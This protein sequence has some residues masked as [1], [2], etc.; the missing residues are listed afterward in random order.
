MSY[1][2]LTGPGVAE[3]L[4]PFVIEPAMPVAQ[5]FARAVERGPEALTDTELLAVLL[6]GA[7]APR[8]AQLAHELIDYFGDLGRLLND[9]P[10]H[11]AGVVDHRT[12]TYIG[13]LRQLVQR[14]TQGRATQRRSLTTWYELHGYLMATMNGRS[15]E[16]L[17]V[18]YLDN[19]NNLIRESCSEGTVNF[20]PVF[21]RTIVHGALS[22]GAQGVVISHV[23]PSQSKTPSRQD[24]DMTRKVKEGLATVEVKLLDHVLI[25]GDQAISFNSLQL[26]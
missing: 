1:A 22:A 3:A 8:E 2:C 18:L 6:R 14:M 23:H 7:D 16:A 11:V 15:I 5:V 24:I 20:A 17:R 9:P 10:E 19:Q 12:A 26:L 21:V 13:A 4:K 25:A